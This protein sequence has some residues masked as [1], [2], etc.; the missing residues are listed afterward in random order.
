MEF[1]IRDDHLIPIESGQAVGRGW[2]NTPFGRP[3]GVTW[4]WTATFDLALCRQVLGGRNAERRGEASAHYGVGRRFSEGVDRYVSIADRSWHAGI[5]QTLR[6]D[7]K[8]L[9]DNRFKGT[10]TTIGVET[11]NIG[12]ARP[13]A[14]KDDDWIAAAEPNGKHLM[15]IQPW[16]PD[17]IKMMIVV[18]KEI[19]KRWDGIKVRDHHGHHDICPGYKQ[20]VA[21]FPFA[22]VLRGIYDEPTIPDVWTPFWMP[23]QRQAAL[24]ALGYNIGTAAPDG[25]W[26]RFSDAAL[27][28][29]Q[30]E[31]GMLADGM[32]T[33]FVN[34]KVY[35]VMKAR[36]MGW[37]PS[38]PAEVRP[39]VVGI[40]RSVAE[41]L[42]AAAPNAS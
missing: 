38:R 42:A 21:G 22:E 5:N 3:V 31:N 26:G 16:H 9:T 11:V 24:Q 39:S 40:G 37:P 41:P 28:K 17:Q 6:W 30:R 4:H 19:V 36:E 27:R 34:W 8:P 1:E 13:A 7:G 15:H 12:F 14:R 23:G 20:D 18:G 33:T 10:R 32:W 35:D 25:D 29:F 2:G